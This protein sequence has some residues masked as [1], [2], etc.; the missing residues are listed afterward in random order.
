MTPKEIVNAIR[1]NLDAVAGLMDDARKL[2][3]DVNFQ[4]FRE[5]KPKA[6][7][8]AKVTATQTI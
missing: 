7:F 2:G 4:I 5:D 3:I 6:K 1:T 8:Q